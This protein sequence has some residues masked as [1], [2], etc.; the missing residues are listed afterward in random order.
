M[1]SYSAQ[2]NI[3]SQNNWKNPNETTE[4]SFAFLPWR[5]EVLDL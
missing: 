4:S 2:A 1:I 5:S 3:S